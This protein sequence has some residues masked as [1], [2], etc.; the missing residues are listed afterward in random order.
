MYFYFETY[1]YF[2]STNIFLHIYV[3]IFFNVSWIHQDYE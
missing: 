1:I 2:E 3:C